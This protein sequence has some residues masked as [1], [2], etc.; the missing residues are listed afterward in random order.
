MVAAKGENKKKKP[1]Q[2]NVVVAAEKRENG[3][4]QDKR[5]ST[6]GKISR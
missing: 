2:I 5:V 4:T 3:I 1:R 6:K